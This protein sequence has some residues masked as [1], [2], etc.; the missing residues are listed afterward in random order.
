MSSPK[1]AAT[2]DERKPQSAGKKSQTKPKPNY[3][4]IKDKLDILEK[5]IAWVAQGKTLRDFCRQDGMPSFHA[6]YDWLDKNEEAQR[7][8]AHARDVGADIIAEEGLDILDQFPLATADG[9]IDSAHVAW[10]KNRFEGRLKLL[11]KWNPKKYGDKQTLNH[12]GGVQLN[13]VTGIPSD[14]D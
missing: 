1:S 12:E 11:A 2:K 9:K 6:I 13:V 10:L 8:F 4:D 7:R 14:D 5:A 3:G